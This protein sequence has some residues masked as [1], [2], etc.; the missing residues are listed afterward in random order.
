MIEFLTSPIFATIIS[1][2]GAAGLVAI[3]PWLRIEIDFLLQP[4]PKD[5]KH[6]SVQI[7]VKAQNLGIVP[8]RGHLLLGRNLEDF[9]ERSFKVKGRNNV[10]LTLFDKSWRKCKLNRNSV[11]EAGLGYMRFLSDD[12]ER[13][14]SRIKGG[15]P[16]KKEYPEIGYKDLENAIE[17]LFIPSGF[18]RLFPKVLFKRKVDFKRELLNE[19]VDK[20]LS[21]G[22]NP[23]WIRLS[24]CD[25]IC[26]HKSINTEVNLEKE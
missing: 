7:V 26:N 3:M 24:K 23:E 13:S 22:T 20:I 14:A 1:V 19:G 5:F 18:Y 6:P 2:L 12:D 8:L 11:S 16:L 4:T 15:I 9:S 10:E 21:A 17:I 25:E